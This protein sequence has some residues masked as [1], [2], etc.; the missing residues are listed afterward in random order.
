[1][2]KNITEL[3]KNKL[4][5]MFCRALQRCSRLSASLNAQCNLRRSFGNIEVDVSNLKIR[6]F[7]D[8]V[9]EET[10]K[11]TSVM[12][13]EPLSPLAKEIYQ[14][15]QHRGPITLHDYMLQVIGHQHHG[16]YRQATNI[17]GAEGDFVTSPEISQLFGETIAI[18]LI[19][20]W[21]LMNTPFV[22]NLVEFGPGK[23][24][25]MKDILRVVDRFPKF[26]KSLHIHMVELSDNLRDVQFEA[27]GCQERNFDFQTNI[28]RG[29]TSSGI[30]ISWYRFV[31]EVPKGPSL[32]IAQEFLD[33]FPVHQFYYTANG[34]REKLVDIDTSEDSPYNFRLVLAPS[35]TPAVKAIME[36]TG[37]IA[38]HMAGQIKTMQAMSPEEQKLNAS[39]LETQLISGKSF[40]NF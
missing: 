31:D 27:L 13:K 2:N 34:W 7:F 36:S 3:N 18:W 25:M 11:S 29:K 17:I 35:Q 15:I 21:E 37:R 38:R 16:Y 8:P 24:T 1:M 5:E 10:T 23:G 6:P 39:S 26:R 19:Y 20:V 30:P 9:S 22:I 33:T 40:R 12:A 14:L 32:F 4:F 28:L